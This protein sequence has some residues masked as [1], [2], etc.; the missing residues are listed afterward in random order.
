MDQKNDG[1]IRE[2]SKPTLM[3]CSR[4]GRHLYNDVHQ[5]RRLRDLPVQTSRG[6]GGR[7]LCQVNDEVSYGSVAE[8]NNSQVYTIY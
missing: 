8:K 2:T 5:G 4:S 1:T 6:R 3:A 7:R